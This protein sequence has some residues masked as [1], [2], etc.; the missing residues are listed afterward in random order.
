MTLDYYYI[1]RSRNDDFYFSEYFNAY[2]FIKI[3]Q[4]NYNQILIIRYNGTHSEE[5][6][7]SFHVINL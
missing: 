2:N 3:I 1:K 4:F 7:E 5:W 6:I